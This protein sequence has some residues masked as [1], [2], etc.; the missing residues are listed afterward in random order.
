MGKGWTEGVHPEDFDRCVA[1]Y[2]TAFEKHEAF[3]MEYRLRHVSGEY[4]WILDFGTP[5]YNSKNEFIGYIGN[6]FDITERKQS[7]EDFRNLIELSPVPMAII[8]EWKT[9]YFNPAAVQ[10]FGAS[11]QNEILNKH[12]DQFIHPDYH[13]IGRAHV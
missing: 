8:R 2:V 9:L 12:I 6:C 3:E 1:T 13:E 5:N 4:R 7:E 10:L 11:T